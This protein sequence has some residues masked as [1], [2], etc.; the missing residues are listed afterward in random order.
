MTQAL[1]QLSVERHLTRLGVVFRLARI[2]AGS[3]RDP[4]GE[5]VVRME[6]VV[7][8]LQ[9]DQTPDHQTGAG[10]QQEGESGLS[11]DEDG[12]QTHGAARPGRAAASDCAEQ[13][14][15]GSIHYRR[16]AHH[17]PEHHAQERAEDQDA[18]IHRDAVQMRQGNGE[19]RQLPGEQPQHQPG[20]RD[21]GSGPDTSEDQGLRQQLPQDAAETSSER[22][23]DGDLAPPLHGAAQQ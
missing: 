20:C 9:A 19:H 22:R 1:D 8:L 18:L 2:G 13:I 10:Q 23:A 7:R 11:A 3:D 16:Q 4:H 6:P 5:H 21:T 12:E 15:P 17:A 14:G